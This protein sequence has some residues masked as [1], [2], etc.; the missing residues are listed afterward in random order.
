MSSPTATNRGTPGGIPLHDGFSSVIV[1]SVNATIELYIKSVQPPSTDG[2]DP[3]D[4]TT[5]HNTTYR[6]KYA[7]SLIEHGPGTAKCAYDPNL[8]TSI[9]SLI[10]NKSGSVTYWFA[11][12]S[13]IAFWG[14]LQKFEPQ[15]MTDGAMPEANITVIQTNWDPTAHVEAGPTV[16]NVTGT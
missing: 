3:I 5:M 15:E 14:Y 7:R 1:F 12:G 10:N 16:T 9:I 8:Y 6:T 4:Q 13:N 11:D 2:G